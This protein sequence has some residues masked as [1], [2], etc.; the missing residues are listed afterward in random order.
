MH[1]LAN[2]KV[3]GRSH[4]ESGEVCQDSVEVLSIGGYYVLTLSDGAGSA[5]RSDEGSNSLVSALTEHFSKNKEIYSLF[6]LA[7][8]QEHV[9]LVISQVRTKLI[10]RGELNLFHATLVF[11]VGNQSLVHVFHLGDGAGL[12]GERISKNE[13]LIHRSDPHNGE[14]SNETYF[15]TEDSWQNNLRSFTVKNPAFCVVC[16]DGVDPFLWDSSKGTRF[17]F[18][19]PLLNNV[20]SA[21]GDVVS[22]NKALLNIISDPRADQVTSDD[23]SIAVMCDVNLGTLD[24]IEFKDLKKPVVKDQAMLHEA[25]QQAFTNNQNPVADS[26]SQKKLVTTAKESQQVVKNSPVTKKRGASIYLLFIFL[27]LTLI[28]LLTAALF[29]TD[30]PPIKNLRDKG[31]V[32]LRDKNDETLLKENV[33]AVVIEKNIPKVDPDKSGDKSDDRTSE[34][35]EMPEKKHQGVIKESSEK[36]VDDADKK[37]VEKAPSSE[38]K[39]LP[40]KKAKEVTKEITEK[41]INDADKK[42][43]EKAP[44]LDLDKDTGIKPN[45]IDNSLEKK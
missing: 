21:A 43:V 12:V 45:L 35:K 3:I 29:I 28:S 30:F 25:L 27:I 19:K 8:I 20:I 4:Q 38:K 32:I 17:G 42:I 26:K 10:A 13:I 23:K 36:K 1:F 11:M 40:E 22:A 7:N 6:T 16:S 34:K 5:A 24:E 44:S 14:F 18:L 41:K 37:I 33:E 2:S 39:K 9:C 15:F 31:K